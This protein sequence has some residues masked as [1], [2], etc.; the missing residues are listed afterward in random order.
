MVEVGGKDPAAVREQ[1]QMNWCWQGK[2]RPVPWTGQCTA[3][4]KQSVHLEGPKAY[5]EWIQLEEI[6]WRIAE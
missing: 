5:K 3:G 2:K 6:S 1:G 4:T